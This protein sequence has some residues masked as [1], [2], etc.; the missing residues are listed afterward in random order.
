MRCWASC[1]LLP[2]RV[3]KGPGPL[4]KLDKVPILLGCSA[5]DLLDGDRGLLR[6]ECLGRAPKHRMDSSMGSGMEMPLALR[7]AMRRCVTS[8]SSLG[9]WLCS[10]RS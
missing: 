1:P 4:R 5:E 7:S 2:R 9:S 10:C 8:S 3:S 6:A